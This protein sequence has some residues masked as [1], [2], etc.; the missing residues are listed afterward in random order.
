MV[1]AC[2][3]E[4]KAKRERTETTATANTLLR[5]IIAG[6]LVFNSLTTKASGAVHDSYIVMPLTATKK[7]LRP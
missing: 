5:L 6:E 2:A 1:C 7:T 3:T 4:E